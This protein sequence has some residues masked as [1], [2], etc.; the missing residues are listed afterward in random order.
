MILQALKEYG[1]S[2]K[3][4]AEQGIVADA[5]DDNVTIHWLL[6]IDGGG[7]FVNLH[8]RGVEQRDEKGKKKPDRF[9]PLHRVPKEVIN[10]RSSGGNPQFLTDNLEYYFGI[11]DSKL[12]SKNRDSHVARVKEFADAFPNDWRA[13]AI[14]KFFDN[15]AAGKIQVVWDGNP[16]RGA[17]KLVVKVDTT[18]RRF[19]VKKPK[20]RIAVCLAEDNL[21]PVF[22]ACTNVRVFWSRHFVAINAERQKPGE[23]GNEP[24]C[25]CCGELK[26]AVPTF[27]QFDGL[28]GGK[29][30]LICYGKDAFHSLF[31]LPFSP[32]STSA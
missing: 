16:S 23:A 18:E 21:L 27:D 15:L 31:R 25:I 28:P 12:G 24:P 8:Y 1:D 29:T 11:S 14:K 3:P 20:D 5:F 19:A 17:G 4:A 10:S 6:E 30:Y 22:Q 2:V 26:P 13:Q 32:E 9:A 7:N